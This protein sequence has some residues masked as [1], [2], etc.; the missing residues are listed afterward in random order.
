MK[1]LSLTPAQIFQDFSANFCTQLTG[2]ALL[3]NFKALSRGKLHLKKLSLAGC[4]G[5]SCTSLSALLQFCPKLTHLM[6]TLIGDLDDGLLFALERH[7]PA[8]QS[9]S[10][11]RSAA[12]TAIGV[13]RLAS[14]CLCIKSLDLSSSSSL[15]DNSLIHIAKLAKSLRVRLQLVL[16]LLSNILM[17]VC[18]A[19]GFV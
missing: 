19:L 8:L 9:L 15:T 17:S 5:V 3:S 2:M 10:A 11:A 4:L 12:V 13:R 7:C 14:G 1:N 16:A 6:A 18:L